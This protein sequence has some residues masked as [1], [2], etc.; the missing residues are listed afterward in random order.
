LLA[1]GEPAAGDASL[2]ALLERGE[3]TARAVEDAARRRRELA[4]TRDAAGREHARAAADRAELE[5]VR[6]AWRVE[7]SKAVLP[8]GLGPEPSTEEV[9]AVLG[10]LE[11]LFQKVDEAERARRRA[12]AMEADAERFRAEVLALAREHAPD[13]ASADVERAAGELVRRSQQAR[14]DLATRSALDRELAEKRA[15]QG[16]Q[17]ARGALARA[18]LDELCAAAGAADVAALELAERR[19]AEALELEAALRHAEDKILDAGGDGATVKALVAETRDVDADA[20]AAEL[21]DVEARAE[22]SARRRDELHRRLGEQELGLR[23]LESRSPA[24]DSAAEVQ[25]RLSRVRTEAERWIR[26]R[27]AAAVLAREIERYREANQGPILRRASELY[28]RLTLGGFS[29]LRTGWGANDQAV[30][31][32]VREGGEEVDVTGLSDGARDQLYLALRLATLERQ[33]QAADPLPLVLDDVL[34]Q[35]DDD[36]ARAA[37]AVLGEIAALTQILFFTHHARLLD[38]A[39]EAVPE[40]R[41]RVHRLR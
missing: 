38:L 36:R 6:A 21:E 16:A 9:D 41:L 31:R 28:R 29:G 26:V 17:A 18:R 8:L 14:T 12:A 35:F 11:K 39:R 34:V 7:W 30:L 40:A 5:S 32:C 1:L 22:Q 37:L 13:L 24:A 10:A 25:E 4:R 20:L 2:A 3:A 27:L 23:N 33:A 15:E 19:S